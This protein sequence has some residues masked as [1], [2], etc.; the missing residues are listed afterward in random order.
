MYNFISLYILYSTNIKTMFGM[1]IG[2]YSMSY[3][4]TA[5]ISCFVFTG[6]GALVLALH[7]QHLPPWAR[8]KI[9]H[10]HHASE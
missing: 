6:I 3:R 10:H 5:V 9:Y 2:T 1:T 7:N 4:A 8:N